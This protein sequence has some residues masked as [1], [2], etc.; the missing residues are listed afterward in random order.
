MQ[1]VKNTSVAPLDFILH[2]LTHAA[3]HISRQRL[4]C[5]RVVCQTSRYQNCVIHSVNVQ[6]SVLYTGGRGKRDALNV[7]RPHRC[8]I[9]TKKA[10]ALI[11]QQLLFTRSGRNCCT[12]MIYFLF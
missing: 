8:S 12:G 3:A 10:A 7:D 2:I 11:Q 6:E 4:L 1:R 5:R 9:F